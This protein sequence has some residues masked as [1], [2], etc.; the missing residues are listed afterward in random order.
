[1]TRP[2]VYELLEEI[3]CNLTILRRLS[4]LTEDEFVADPEK[5][6][7]AERCFQ[8]AVQCVLDI[9]AYIASQ[10]GWQRPE[11][12]SEAVAL[13]GRQGVLTME[14]ADRIA[15]MANFRNILVH[16]YLKI[17]RKIVY[18]YLSR[19]DDFQEFARQILA[20]LEHDDS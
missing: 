10:K 6:L 9:S 1:L 19:L 16:A 13:M 14:F 3:Q 7:L 20:F 5:Y 8:L 2:I 12:S 15:G 4:Q 18:R 17:D 11:N